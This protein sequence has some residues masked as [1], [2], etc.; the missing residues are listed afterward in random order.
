M[1]TQVHLN[2]S[3][4]SGGTIFASTRHV[5]WALNT[6]KCI[7]RIFCVRRIFGV[8]VVGPWERVC[9]RHVRQYKRNLKFGANVA[10]S[11]C[12][13][14]YTVYTSLTV[15]FYTLFQRCF[16]IQNTW[17]LGFSCLAIL[18]HRPI[19]EEFVKCQQLPNGAVST[20]FR[21]EGIS[22]DQF[23]NT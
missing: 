11:E 8:N 4:V 13:L 22:Q 1:T 10:V 20:V 17:L 23:I 6:P 5:P 7:R 21:N 15:I 18:L 9:W 14:C 19:L 2:G 16:N 12:T 3:A